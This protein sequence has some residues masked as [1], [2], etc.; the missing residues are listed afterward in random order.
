[1]ERLIDDCI[2]LGRL[3]PGQMQ[4]PSVSISVIMASR[5]SVFDDQGLLFNDGLI[6]ACYA[7]QG[8]LIS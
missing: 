5:F 6:P 3:I 2:R 1:M 7:L 4:L 8:W